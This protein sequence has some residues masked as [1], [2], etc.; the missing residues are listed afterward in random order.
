MAV[1]F[2]IFHTYYF[3]VISSFPEEQNNPAHTAR[4]G[5]IPAA[6]PQ[7]PQALWETTPISSIRPQLWGEEIPPPAPQVALSPKP[8]KRDISR[9]TVMGP[10]GDFCWDL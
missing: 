9:A 10:V 5:W 6:A 4:W 2:F 8:W 3:L 7:P 1:V